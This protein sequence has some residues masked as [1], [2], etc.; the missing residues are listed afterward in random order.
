MKTQYVDR[1]DGPYLY[2]SS[3]VHN[4]R[5]ANCC[6]LCSES[7]YNWDVKCLICTVGLSH[8]IVEEKHICDK[9]KSKE[10]EL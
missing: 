3:N 7:F 8:M 5:M 9:F 1:F 2:K 6:K 10:Q 4:Y